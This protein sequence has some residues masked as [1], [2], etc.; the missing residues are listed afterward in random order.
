MGF[1]DKMLTIDRR[2]IFLAVGVAIIIPFFFYIGLPIK[3][4]SEVKALHDSVERLKPGDVVFFAPEYDPGTIP[5]LQPMCHAFLRQCFSK[6]IKILA[7]CLF[8]LGPAQAEQDVTLI[9]REFNLQ[10]GV[11][12]VYLGYK[13]Y[14]ETVILNMGEDFRKSFPKDYYGNLVDTLPMMRNLKNYSDTK[15]IV[16]INATSGADYW[17]RSARGRY[18]IPLGLGVTAV[19]ATDYYTYLQSGQ[20]FALVGGMKGAAE[21]EQLVGLE[22]K[23]YNRATA[24]MDIQNFAHLVIIFF[25]ILGNVAYFATRGKK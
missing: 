5:E 14:P 21:M 8:Q 3:V 10:Y 4:T 16:S 9:A 19:M 25:V 15:M 17:I 20:L 22:G 7:V 13:P 1:F 2:W 11:D 12:Y 24:R 18:N 6:K 23:K